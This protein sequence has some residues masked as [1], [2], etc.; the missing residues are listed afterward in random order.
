MAKAPICTYSYMTI[1]EASEHQKHQH[2]SQMIEAEQHT[3]R[4]M[5]F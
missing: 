4:V 5:G 3:W 1:E 2:R